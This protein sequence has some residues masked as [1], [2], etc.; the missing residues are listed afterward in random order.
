MKHI[1]YLAIIIGLC[2]ALYT[3]GKNLPTDTMILVSHDVDKCQD[4]GS[5]CALKAV[6]YDNG[7]TLYKVI[8]INSKD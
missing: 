4:N 8:T 3:T 1:I 6:G 7:S 2:I 5:D